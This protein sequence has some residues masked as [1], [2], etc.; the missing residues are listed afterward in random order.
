MKSPQQSNLL[1]GWAGWHAEAQRVQQQSCSLSSLTVTTAIFLML[2]VFIIFFLSLVV[3]YI[4]FRGVKS[5]KVRAEWAS[6]HSQFIL[7]INLSAQPI[8]NLLLWFLVHPSS[9][10]SVITSNLLYWFPSLVWL[11]S[12]PPHVHPL[13]WHPVSCSSLSPALHRLSRHLGTVNKTFH[14][15]CIYKLNVT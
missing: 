2:K 9:D 5:R 11:P 10:F 3:H 8:W 14:A 15:S 1:T 13:L 12:P 6:I 4:I 7:V